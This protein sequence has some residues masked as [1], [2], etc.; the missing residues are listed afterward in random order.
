MKRKVAVIVTSIL[1]G[2]SLAYSYYFFKLAFKKVQKESKQEHDGKKISETW[3]PHLSQF[4]KGQEWFHSQKKEKV[5]IVS[6]DGLQLQGILLSHKDEKNII[7]AIHG[8]HSSGANDYAVFG[9]FYQKQ[10]YQMLIVDARAHG[11]SEGD[12]IGF[13][14]H[15]KYD[16]ICWI[17]YLVKRFG[18][19]CNIVM[20]GISMGAATVL[21]TGGETLLPQVKGIIADCSYSSA[22]EEFRH[23][24]RNHYHLPAFPIFHI[25]TFLAKMKAGFYVKEGSVIKQTK[26]IQIPVLFIHGELDDFVPTRMV[27]QLYNACK[28]KKYLVLVKNAAH[29]ISYYVDTEKYEN[30]VDYYLKHVI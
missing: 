8:F 9:E 13:G 16:C 30:A 27:Y 6:K 2:I 10:G 29:A 4:Q 28:A 15:E 24:I 11:E 1:S 17:E 22:E 5:N 26:K 3:K 7:L 23:L 12:Y 14:I 19:D 18:Q 25:T 21:M 20:H